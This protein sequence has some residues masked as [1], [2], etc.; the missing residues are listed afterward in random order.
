MGLLGVCWIAISSIE[1]NFIKTNE[2]REIL[3]P[4]LCCSCGCG[5]KMI[6]RTTGSCSPVLLEKNVISVL[7]VIVDSPPQKW[8][9]WWWSW[10]WST[11]E[12]WMVRGRRKHCTVCV[13]PRHSFFPLHQWRARTPGNL[14][15]NALPARILIL[16]ST[17]SSLDNLNSSDA[18]KFFVL[19]LD[20]S[21]GLLL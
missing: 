17:T 2:S 1:H 8:W 20:N 6:A 10:R 3:W 5:R 13:L 19:N 16:L 12:K 18:T 21:Y 15:S 9:W 14:S 11:L 4:S 7:V